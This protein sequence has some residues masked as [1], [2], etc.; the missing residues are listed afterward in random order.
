MYSLVG[1]DTSPASSQLQCSREPTHVSSS[2]ATEYGPNT[3]VSARVT[4]A[5]RPLTS[6]GALAALSSASS[7][8]AFGF[9]TLVSN[10]EQLAA[11]IAAPAIRAQAR[12]RIR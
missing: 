10:T 5:A 2:L 4:D 3:P 9:V 7:V 12:D 11:M 6:G 1:S 8:T